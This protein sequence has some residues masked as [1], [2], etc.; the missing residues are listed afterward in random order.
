MACPWNKL[1]RILDH[2]A[3]LHCLQVLTGLP[4]CFP[5]CVF[6]STC[7][8]YIYYNSIFVL[9]KFSHTFYLICIT[10]EFYIQKNAA[11]PYKTF[12]YPCQSIRD[13]TVAWRDLLEFWNQAHLDGL[14]LEPSYSWVHD[15]IVTGWLRIQ[16]YLC[17]HQIFFRLKAVGIIITNTDV[18]FYY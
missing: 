5:V 13:G 4:A 7:L 16:I 15:G 3:T 17:K 10:H 2:A 18:F 8:C 1:R 9:K 14:K 11:I 6:V 12:L